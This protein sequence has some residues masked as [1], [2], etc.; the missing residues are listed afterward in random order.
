[1]TCESPKEAWEKLISEFEGSNRVR[2]V[3]LLT[4]KCE[5]KMLRMKKSEKMKD[6]SA[7]LMELVNNIRLY[8]ETY[9]NS[10]VVEK[11]LI[12][13]PARFESRISAIEESCDLKTL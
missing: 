12:S 5:F 13:L 4:L 2:V 8:G 10:K 11:N 3:K 1:M 6:Y 7:K 9:E